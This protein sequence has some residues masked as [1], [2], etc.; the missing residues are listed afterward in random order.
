MVTHRLQSKC[1]SYW[2]TV[3]M[4]GNIYVSQVA[5]EL[6]HNHR[7]IISIFSAIHFHTAAQKYSSEMG[8]CLLGN[9]CSRFTLSWP[10]LLSKLNCVSLKWFWL[11]TV[12]RA[13][14]KGK[15][16]LWKWPHNLCDW[17]VQFTV[18]NL[19]ICPWLCFISHYY[20]HRYNSTQVKFNIFSHGF[21]KRKLFVT[22]RFLLWL[23]AKQ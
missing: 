5:G 23:I 12:W 1:F 9:P 17:Q 14:P 19:N 7:Q 11:L 21:T 4:Y 6:K 15:R 22:I 8:K 18:F 13:E 20:W 3:P 16:S 2:E 10:A